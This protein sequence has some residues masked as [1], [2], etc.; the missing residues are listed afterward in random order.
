MD[1]MSEALVTGSHEVL[2]DVLPPPEVYHNEHHQVMYSPCYPVPSP[3]SHSKWKQETLES[4]SPPISIRTPK[5]NTTLGFLS[6]RMCQSYAGSL[7]CQQH[8][9]AGGSS[10]T[11]GVARWV[12]QDYRRSACMTPCEN[13]CNGQHF[14]MKK[15]SLPGY[16]LQIVPQTHPH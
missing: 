1:E 9:D 7:H 8:Q 16:L 2:K 12:I 15:E 6:T 10:E 13:N 4:R 3:W 5:A 11:G 14:N